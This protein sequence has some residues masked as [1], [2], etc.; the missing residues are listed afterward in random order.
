MSNILWGVNGHAW[1]YPAYR[2]NMDEALELAAELGCKIYRIN[3]KPTNEEQ[4]ALLSAYID[5]IHAHGM[6]VLLVLDYSMNYNGPLEQLAAA[7]TFIAK[8]LGNKVDYYQMFNETDCWACRDE[9]GYYDLTDPTGQSPSFFNPVRVKRAVELMK[10][11]LPALQKAAPG[12]PVCVNISVRHYP[13][14]DA[15]REAGL[16]WDI[17]GIDNYEEWDYAAFFRFVKEHYEGYDLMV[18]ECNYPALWGPFDD[19]DNKEADWLRMFLPK[20]EEYGLE[21]DH[22]KAVIIY[23]QLDQPIYEQ[24]RGSYHGESH[25]GLVHVDENNRIVGK[26]PAFDV[27]K[28]FFHRY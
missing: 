18:V 3:Y 10:A 13:I 2:P 8:G 23:E 15:Y 17:I 20:M 6:K 22:L 14:L 7:V 26:R 16:E 11:A 28:E 5:K 21:S 19:P 12:I 9:N 27:A 1:H 4:L 25:F 24:E